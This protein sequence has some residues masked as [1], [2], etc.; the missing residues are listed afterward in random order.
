V[1]EDWWWKI[2]SRGL[3]DDWW[4]I[5]G[6]LVEGWWKMGGGLC[7]ETPEGPFIRKKKP[8]PKFVA[9]WA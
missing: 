2:G 8:P 4:M 3:V 1:V 7:Y 6:R 9:S 5:G